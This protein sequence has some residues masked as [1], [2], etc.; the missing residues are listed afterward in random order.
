V[1]IGGRRNPMKNRA[2]YLVIV[3]VTLMGC[4]LSS[5]KTF[6]SDEG[7]F[8]VSFPGSPQQDVQNV[9]TA[10]GAIAMYTFMVEKSDSAYMV[11][12]SDY[13]P[14]LVNET[15]PDVILSGARDGAVAN[16]QG[17]LLNEVFISLQ[18]HMGREI[19]VETAGAEAFARVRIYL[20]GNRMYQI[21][22][23]TS[24]EDASKDED[25]TN[26]LNSF[27]VLE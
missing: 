4:G 27:F 6:T 1:L 22:A 5:W 8:S 26:Y 7:S 23:L 2:L 16:V 11:A 17:R 24:T 3:A 15:P 19:T 18:G 12:Y 9:N 14:S 21:M 10:V 13:P 20:V 25:I